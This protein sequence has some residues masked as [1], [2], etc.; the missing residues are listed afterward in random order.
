[1]PNARN[2]LMNRFFHDAASPPFPTQVFHE[3][4]IRSQHTG[5]L[6]WLQ[7]TNFT[8]RIRNYTDPFPESLFGQ[9]QQVHFGFDRKLHIS[10]VWISIRFFDT[11][12]R[13][14]AL[15]LGILDIFFTAN[16]F[17]NIKK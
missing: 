5:F 16:C 3:K 2:V 10:F 4:T 6:P 13:P 11:F 9:L 15:M 12:F 7:S 17:K 1:M 8:Q 14:K